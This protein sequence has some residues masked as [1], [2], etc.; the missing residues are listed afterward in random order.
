LT[1]EQFLVDEANSISTT[2]VRART[3]PEPVNIKILGLL[4]EYVDARARFSAARLQRQDLEQSTAVAKRLQDQMWEQAVLV[5]KTAPTAITSL[6]IS[7]AERDHRPER[8]T[9]GHP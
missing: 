9:P 7:V 2:A 5:A 6:F 3:L 1:R 8:K 4:R